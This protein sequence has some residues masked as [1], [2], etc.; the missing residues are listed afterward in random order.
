MSLV[1]CFFTNVTCG[2]QVSNLEKRLADHKVKMDGIIAQIGDMGQDIRVAQ[3]DIN[4]YTTMIRHLS[5]AESNPNLDETKRANAA[6]RLIE[7]EN[8]LAYAEENVCN[9]EA[10]KES[11]HQQELAM[12]T[13]QKAIEVE[14][15]YSKQQGEVFQK[16][17]GDA[18]KRLVPQIG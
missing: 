13:E 9:V 12:Q 4:Q 7:L 5:I 14:L 11:L 8:A 10:Q 6:Q 18:I 16:M 15:N 2:I 1:A 3:K 17:Q